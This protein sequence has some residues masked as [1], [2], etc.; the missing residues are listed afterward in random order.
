MTQIQKCLWRQG[1]TEEKVTPIA[2]S[3]SENRSSSFLHGSNTVIF[4][5]KK[6]K[7][8]TEESETNHSK[9]KARFPDTA[10]VSGGPG[11]YE[12]YYCICSRRH[13]WSFFL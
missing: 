11:E 9:P 5:W 7:P 4:L 1:K 13:T 12:G 2:Q 8:E 10:D 6:I 3:A